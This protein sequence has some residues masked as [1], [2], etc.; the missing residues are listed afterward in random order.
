M[1]DRL[2]ILP[3]DAV[4]FEMEDEAVRVLRVRAGASLRGRFAGLGLTRA[5]EADRRHELLR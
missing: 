2:G 3:G 5:L 1:R 4:Q